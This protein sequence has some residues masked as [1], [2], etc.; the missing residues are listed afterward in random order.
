MRPEQGNVI[1]EKER[2]KVNQKCSLFEEPSNMIGYDVTEKEAKTISKGASL[3][4]DQLLFLRI[5]NL[6][7]QKYLRQRAATI[8]KQKQPAQI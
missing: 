4:N 8:Q 3:E 1:F 6:T 7:G 2:T 5:A